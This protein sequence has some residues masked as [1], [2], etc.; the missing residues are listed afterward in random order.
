M[1]MNSCVDDKLSESEI[2]S[3]TVS[4]EGYSLDFRIN[5][6][7]MGGSRAGGNDI[8]DFEDYIDPNNIRILFFYDEKEGD[9]NSKVNTLIKSFKITSDSNPDNIDIIPIESAGSRFSKDWHIR[10]PISEENE[11]FAQE[12]RDNPF[13]IAIL[14]N[15]PAIPS[16]SEFN[17]GDHINKLHHLSTDNTYSSN[18]EVY[19]FLMEKEKY[20]MKMGLNVDWVSKAVS[21]DDAKSFILTKFGPTNTSNPDPEYGDLWLLWNFD[22]AITKDKDSY[23]DITVFAQEWADKN[24]ADL[25]SWLKDSNVSTPLN[26]FSV[27]D[28]NNKPKDSGNFEF[29]SGS[30]YLGEKNGK[31]GIVLSPGQVNTTGAINNDG[32]KFNIPNAGILTIKWEKFDEDTDGDVS[33]NVEN[34]NHD[35][36]SQYKDDN[37]VVTSSPFSNSYKI[38]GDAEFIY[39]YSTT[40]NVIIYEIEYISSDYITNTKRFGLAPSSDQSIPMYGIQKYPALDGLWE[41]GTVFDLYNY[42]RLEELGENFKSIYLLRS[43]A[44]VELKIPKS[45]GSHHVFLR[46]LNRMSNCEP[47]DVS[48][49]TNEFWLDDVQGAHNPNCEFFGITGHEPFYNPNSSDKNDKTKQL[50]NYQQKL[51]WYF[52]NWSSDSKTLGGV[53]INKG[54]GKIMDHFPHI[55]NPLINR[56]DFARFIENNSDAYYDRYILYV[57]EKFVD[58]PGSIGSNNNMETTTPKICHIEFRGEFDPYTNVDDNNCFRIYFTEGGFNSEMQYPTFEKDPN[59]SS[60]DYNWENY[61]ENQPNN[62]KKHWPIIRNH[63]YSFTVTEVNNRIV[64]VKLEVLPWMMVEDNSYKW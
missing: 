31:K 63:V 49:P 21:K 11:S 18:D 46:S 50:A 38:T 29:V 55:M 28:S 47:M 33:I 48:T 30:S 51:A 5:L 1:L 26:S 10:I 7:S 15:W 64:V 37:P 16:E 24:Y 43:V 20:G 13:K 8:E 57:P 25:N 56:S 60:K 53:T 40:G 52:G 36:D 32:I 4:E 14:A 45:I 23:E 58:D 34:R 42:N 54:T 22:G 61:Y 44:K 62:L 12:L 41:K 39:V 9:D 2:S 6:Q 3:P 19:G 17:E 35:T 59:N 27:L